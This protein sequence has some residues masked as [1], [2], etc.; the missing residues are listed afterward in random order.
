MQAKRKLM[1]HTEPV[2]QAEG[3]RRL[4]VRPSLRVVTVIGAR[5]GLGATSVVVNLAAA[6]AR[7]G[8]QVL[9]LDENLAHDNV[10][11]ALALKPRFDLLHAVRDSLPW[12]DIVLHTAAGVNVLPVARAM[13]TLSRLSVAERDRLQESISAA[14]WGMDVVL[15][16]AT[17]D[18]HSVCASLSGD[19]PLLLVLNAT[20]EGITESYALLK[21][22]A[23]HTGRHA[24]DIV[25]NKVRTEQ[26]ACTVF[27]NMAQV[28]QR[29]LQVQLKYTGSI[30]QDENMLEATQWHR[31]LVEVLP[32]APASH[33]FIE[34]ARNLMLPVIA[35]ND[36][37]NALKQLMGR[38]LQQKTLQRCAARQ[39]AR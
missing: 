1:Q 32:A 15:V 5:P 16:D 6:L 25:V 31:P 9:V 28:A 30:P 2:D 19:E 24:F 14:S 35:E 17:T 3:L 4:L 7:T 38:L 36:G 10:A 37:N 22:L 34:L 29:H 13:Q 20:A 26:E 18:G 39:N 12:R 23:A 27:D 21:K 11:N 8:K 33:A